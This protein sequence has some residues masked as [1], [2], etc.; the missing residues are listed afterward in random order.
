M[1]NMKCKDIPDKPILKFLLRH[2][3]RWATWSNDS[4][5]MPTVVNAMPK[6]IPRKL[7]LAKMRMMIR[8]GVVDGCGC[9][10]RGDFEITKKGELE[11][12]QD[13]Q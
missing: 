11:L 2:R 12:L 8:R 7:V 1:T 5:F 10:C 4:K 13:I 6:G 9:G 3:G